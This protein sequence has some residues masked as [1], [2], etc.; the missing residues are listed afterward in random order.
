M[1]QAPGNTKRRSAFTILEV[2]VTC[3]VLAVFLAIL[4]GI[5]SA[6]MNLWRGTDSKIYADR[7]SRAARLQISQDL[8]NAVVPANPNLWP[9]V[10]N[11]GGNFYLQIL[12]KADPEYQDDPTVDTGTV[13]FAEYATAEGGT[14]LTRRF[15]GSR[16]TFD[17]IL[18]TG[19]FPQPG[20][21]PAE[22]T[23]LLAANLLP[24]N[25]DAVRGL[26]PLFR[27]APVLKFVVL[28]GDDLL[29]TPAT[30]SNPPRAIEINFAVTDPD[31]ATPEGL[32]L[33]A[34]PSYR[35]RD[36]GLYSFRIALPAPAAQ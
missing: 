18:Q 10:I 17:S 29:P 16:E 8:A 20:S 36:A 34:D 28:T 35:L 9:R 23:Q 22:Q 4:L 33:L 11:Q 14:R 7:E 6:S 27:E 32:E 13:C 1:N 19:T 21:G 5:F 15:L 3:A 30:P 31:S 12:T 24:V 25:A 2:L 26:G